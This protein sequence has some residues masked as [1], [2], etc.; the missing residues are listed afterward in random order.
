ML[1]LF[2]SHSKQCCIMAPSVVALFDTTLSPLMF[3][4]PTDLRNR[5]YG[6]EQL[7]LNASG[8]FSFSAAGA[9]AVQAS[10]SPMHELTWCPTFQTYLCVTASVFIRWT[11]ASNP[12]TIWP[13]A[14]CARH[15]R[16][17]CTCS[18]TILQSTHSKEAPEAKHIV[19]RNCWQA[20]TIIEWRPCF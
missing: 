19:H 20:V 1:F 18:C 2:H 8:L 9:G 7:G 5:T 11:P 16:M 3:S 15:R 4:S 6:T 12:S 10:P 14:V 13:T 17:Q